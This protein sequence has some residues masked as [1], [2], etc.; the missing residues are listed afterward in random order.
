MAADT[1]R[2]VIEKADGRISWPKDAFLRTINGLP[3]GR[4]LLTVGRYQ[5]PITAEQRGFWYGALIRGLM[6]EGHTTPLEAHDALVRSLATLPWEKIRPSTSDAQ[7]GREDFSDLI[8][9]AC[10]FL[11]VDLG[12]EVPDM[13]GAPHL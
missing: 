9:R 6:Q 13:E 1:T 11:V 4:Y 12:L 5:K 3:D 2:I 7:M 10:A 8:E